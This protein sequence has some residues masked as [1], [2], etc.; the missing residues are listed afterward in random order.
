MNHVTSI[1][2]VLENCEIME[3][4]SR[5]IGQFDLDNIHLEA[6]RIACN[7]LRSYYQCDH[8]FIEILPDETLKSVISRL[9]AYPDITWCEL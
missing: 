4:P 8:F 1:R 3:I 9:Q 6:G 7:E 5:C 2:L